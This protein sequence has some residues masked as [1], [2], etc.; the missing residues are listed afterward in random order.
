M[1]IAIIIPYF[2]E[3]PPWINF[4]VE[5]CRHNHDIDWI[6][7]N[8]C[9]PPT[10][11]S[12]NVRHVQIDFEDYKSLVSAALGIR[13]QPADPYKLCDL[14]PALAFVHRDLVAG[15]DFVGFGDLDIIYGDIRSFYNDEIL[16]KSDLLSS[17]CDRISGHLCLMRNNDLMVTA[18]RRVPG[19]I[20]L[21][22][23]PDH[24]EF[25]EGFFHNTVVGK[26]KR[27]RR[28]APLLGVRSFFRE[29]Y[30]TP[31]VTN[32]MRW[33]WKGGKLTNEFYPHHPFMY[34]H[35]MSWHSNRWYKDQPGAQA[36]A[37]APWSLLPELVQIDWQDARKHGFMISPQGIQPIEAPRYP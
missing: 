2:G 29:T 17:H 7:F 27:F 13:F 20:G 34:L 32:R 28:A 19:W 24:V 25:D 11:L 15:Y 9:S 23:R 4:F 3:W 6:L 26:R 22:E 37:P 16:A 1:S 30:S 10:N 31:G 5:S 14:K 21:L 36:A 33:Y 8:S 35:F 12:R 18:F